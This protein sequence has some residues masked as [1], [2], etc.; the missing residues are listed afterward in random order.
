MNVS[1]VTNSDPPSLLTR[2]KI[3]D[4]ALSKSRALHMALITELNSDGD[5]VN[6]GFV[7]A[8][9]NTEWSSIGD[10]LNRSKSFEAVVYLCSLIVN[11]DERGGRRERKS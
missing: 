9:L 3:N 11:R 7:S 4:H 10:E 1:A 5:S 2:S 6:V 8:H